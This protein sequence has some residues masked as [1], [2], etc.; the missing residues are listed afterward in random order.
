MIYFE[1]KNVWNR[2]CFYCVITILGMI[3]FSFLGINSTTFLT[4]IEYE[5]TIE[6]GKNDSVVDGRNSFSF[7]E[8]PIH[9]AS[10]Y[11]ASDISRIL[12]L[13]ADSRIEVHLKA[14]SVRRCH[15]PL[16]VGR[17]SGW[18]LSIIDF[19]SLE[20]SN[21]GN[22]DI[23]VGTYDLSMMP[24]SGTYFLE[25]IVM[26]CERYDSNKNILDT[27]LRTVWL[28]DHTEESHQITQNHTSIDI[29]VDEKTIDASQRNNDVSSIRG[30][31]LHNSLLLASSGGS[32]ENISLPPPV[33]TR[34]QPAIMCK[35]WKKRYYNDFCAYRM[36]TKRFDNYAFQ[37]N[38]GANAS[39]SGLEVQTENVHVCF[40]GASHSREANE[41]CNNVSNTTCSNAWVAYPHEVSERWVQKFVV[42]KE[43]THAVV[44]LF[45]WFF[46]EE[47][48][49]EDSEYFIEKSIT[50]SDWKAQMTNA[51]R[52]LEKVARDS[53]TPLRKVLLRSAHANGN[54][55]FQWQRQP[56]NLR[57]LPNANMATSI[58][59]EIAE[60][61]STRTTV[62]SGNASIKE[63]PTVSF[64]DTRFLIDPVW[65]SAMDFSHH[66]GE[67]GKEEV[68]FILSEILNE[69]AS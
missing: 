44:G 28:E 51:T 67:A 52:I 58:V 59:K 26:L 69:E 11:V 3:F 22:N 4:L 34:Y 25:I 20:E 10:N 6:T 23:V 62:N 13:P 50:F 55:L 57:T 9:N 41:H 7:I 33:Y 68:K 60:G 56:E 5:P 1:R 63:I 64:I 16:F 49:M 30:R 18:S 53:R 42:K 12:H 29:V 2:R 45:Q 24:V 37:W 65:D 31:W 39:M 14:K 36:S 8:I 48:G 35:K 17:L 66:L 32:L 54:L 19:E 61:F 40:V 15:N 43:C 21:N 46:S 47:S 27:N 38:P